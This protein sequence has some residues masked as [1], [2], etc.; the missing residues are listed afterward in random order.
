MGWAERRRQTLLDAEEQVP[1]EI[2][3]TADEK[4]ADPRTANSYP[5][6]TLRP[7]E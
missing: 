5:R 1:D 3:P 6:G 7:Q 2:E 4:D